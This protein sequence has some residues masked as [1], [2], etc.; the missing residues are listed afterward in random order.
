M[1]GAARQALRWRVSGR[2]QGVFFRA[3][4]RE[5][6]LRLGL[7]GS[8]VNREDGAVEVVAAGAPQAL[9]ELEDWLRQGPPRARVE[10]LERLPAPDAGAVPAGF[11][12]G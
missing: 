8:A 10:A 9:A 3:S 2:V 6:A 1:S 7:D 12:I 11:A 5:Q 4:A